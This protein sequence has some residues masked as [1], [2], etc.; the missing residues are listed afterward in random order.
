MVLHTAIFSTHIMILHA[1]SQNFTEEEGA[2]VGGHA[3]KFECSQSSSSG[4]LRKVF[5]AEGLPV[6]LAVAV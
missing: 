1:L 3:P 5:L 2:T 4:L 6:H